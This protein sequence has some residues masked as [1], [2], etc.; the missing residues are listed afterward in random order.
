MLN[1]SF[2][3]SPLRT[4]PSSLRYVRS[5]ISHQ[6][7]SSGWHLASY[8]ARQRLQRKQQVISGSNKK[9]DNKD[10]NQH[11][12]QENVC[13]PNFLPKDTS[14]YNKYVFHLSDN[15]SYHDDSWYD[16]VSP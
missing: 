15:P 1:H 10:N 11:H 13:K 9:N 2:H 16:A 6:K 12:N 3:T 14:V 8:Y 4:P 7:I 5:N